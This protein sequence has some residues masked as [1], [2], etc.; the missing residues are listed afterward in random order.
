M[1]VSDKRPSLVYECCGETEGNHHALS[2]E[3]VP[4]NEVWRVMR[5]Q[6]VTRR[7][8]EPAAAASARLRDRLRRKGS[9]VTPNDKKE[10]TP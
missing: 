3:R 8:A 9:Y 10:T 6:N 1:S 4:A 7:Q 5:E 2:C